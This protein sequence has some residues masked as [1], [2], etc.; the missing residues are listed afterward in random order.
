MLVLG[1]G[2]VSTMSP[3]YAELQCG[4][5]VHPGVQRC[6]AGLNSQLAFISAKQQ[7][8][9]QWCWA[10]CIEMV[11]RYYGYVVP[12]ERIV[13]ETWGSLV[14]MPGY[15]GQ[16][17]ANLNRP[18]QDDFGRRFG[19]SGDSFTAN[20]ITASQDLA[21]GRPLI[22]G[23]M[24]HAMVLTAVTFDRDSHGNGQVVSA[25]VRDPWEDR[26]RRILTAQ[27]WFATTFLA[28]IS[29]ARW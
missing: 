27:E 10:A 13:S 8:N 26:G 25:I 3:A 14:N 1:A 18:W 29:V 22:I 16:I 19:V 7:R 11:F 21:G 12:Q 17:L 24:G 6:H 28:R 9:S 23:S 20:P 2:A 5:W 15:P 4:P